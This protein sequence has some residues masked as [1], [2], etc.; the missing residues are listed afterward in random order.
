MG[1]T[2]LFCNIDDF[3]G[4]FLPEYHKHL[5]DDGKIKRVRKSTLSQSEVMTII[6]EFQRSG[7]R[8][9]KHY[10]QRHVCVHLRWAF[11]QVV[12]YNRFV[13]L[14][15]EA[16]VPLCAY[17]ST[18]KGTCSGI[19][20]IDSMPIAV[21]H[22]RRIHSHQVFLETAQRGKNSVGWFY[23]FKLHLVV[24]DCGE[25]LAIQLTPGNVDDRTPVPKMVKNLF[26]KLFGD[27]GY[28]SQPLFDL[29]FDDDVQLVTKIRK[30]MENKLMPIFDKLMLRKRAIIE[31]IYDQLKN[32][33]Q[34]EH[35]RHRSGFNFLVNVISALIAYTYQEK[36]PSLNIRLPHSNDLP[37]VIV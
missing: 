25:L 5:I 16:L 12:S 21:C 13:E 26:G 15:G 14:M 34:V 37:A 31:T 32:I 35:T 17:L 20:F 28:I 10:Y 30:N 18:R 23:G 9:F 1:L 29:L 4:D 7:Y 2:T 24:N 11:P 27:K 19:S 22:N 6:I 36:K 8:T 33:S 3:C